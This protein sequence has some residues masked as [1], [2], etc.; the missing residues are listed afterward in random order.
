[1][2]VLVVILLTIVV[3]SYRQTIYAYPS[4]GGS[5]IVS[6]ENLGKIPA[7]VAGSSLLADY[8]LTVA[9]SIA[10]GVGAI[11]SAF[12]RSAS[13]PRRPVPG[14]R[15][16]HDGGQPAWGARVRRPVRPAHLHL[17]LRSRRTRHLRPLPNLLP[18][19]RRDPRPRGRARRAHRGQ[20]GTEHERVTVHA[21]ACLLVG[22]HRPHRHR[23]SLQ[24]RAGVPQAGGPQR[25]NHPGVDGRDPRL[26][27]L[28]HRRVGT[29]PQ[30]RTPRG[31]RNR[32]LDHGQSRVRR[33]DVHVLPPP[34]LHLRHLD[35]RRQHRLRRL[36]PAVRD[37]RPRRLPAPPTRQPRRPARLLQRHPRALRPRRNTHRRV[38]R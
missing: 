26:T 15:R 19:P 12:A 11:T 20:R 1:M 23:S 10:A 32:A 5:Y 25:R 14:G 22:R 24:R 2:A 8:V 16:A 38:R 9:V 28:R 17:R 27:V 37:R 18:G 29:P 3:L 34:I 30:A 4:G 7:L 36:P 33:R 35:P 21:D 6:R 13:V 31:R